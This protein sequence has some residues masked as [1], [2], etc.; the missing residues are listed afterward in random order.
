M[1]A[2]AVCIFWLVSGVKLPWWL[3]AV[4]FVDIALSFPGAVLFY[5]RLFQ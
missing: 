5:I 1:S 4:V 3:W 2:T